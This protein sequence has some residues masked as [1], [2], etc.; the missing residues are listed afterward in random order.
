VEKTPARVF[1]AA[2]KWKHLHGRGEDFPALNQNIV[3]QETPPRA[4]RRLTVLDS[5]A[6][7]AR[8][9]STGVEKTA[10]SASFSIIS[11]KH[12]HGR[13]EDH[14][15]GIESCC[16][17]ETPPRAWRRQKSPQMR[18]IFNGNTSTGV[19]KTAQNAHF[20]AHR[21]K[22]L[23]GRGEDGSAIN[24]TYSS[25]ET[26]PRA[27]R[28][29][30]GRAGRAACLGNT[31]T[32]VEKTIWTSWS[33]CLSRKHLHGRGEDSGPVATIAASTETPPRAWRR[34]F[35]ARIGQEK[36][37]NTSTGVEKTH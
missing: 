11:Q 27:W 14:H 16:A 8:N 13:G 21:K 15:P 19:E 20:R 28:R 6:A 10:D 12:L 2:G 36:I 5:S 4:W 34:P 23:H 29:R 33:R 17:T 7:R 9:T 18:A 31:S 24:A 1:P 26:P 3:F 37:R 35:S 22:H 32:G 30:Y 25:T